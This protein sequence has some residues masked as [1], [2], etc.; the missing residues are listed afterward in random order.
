MQAIAY[1]RVSTKKQSKS[2]LGLE[3]QQ[4]AVQAFAD[5]EGIEL[6]EAY[7]EVETGKGH[8]WPRKASG[9]ISGP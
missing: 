2:G 1:Y 8:E 6:L 9:A 4:A 5:R 7:T 3:A